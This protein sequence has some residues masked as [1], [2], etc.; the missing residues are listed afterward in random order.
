LLGKG[1]ANTPVEK[2]WLGIRHVTAAI[3]AY[4]TIE[5]LEEAGETRTCLGEN[6]N[7]VMDL[8]ETEARNDSA[9]EG[10]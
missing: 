7:L 5:E 2:Q 3:L 1:S 8:E 9:G 4:G 6:K 10:Q